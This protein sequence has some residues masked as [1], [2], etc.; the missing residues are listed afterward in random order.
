MFPQ[1]RKYTLNLWVTASLE[2]MK[3]LEK[4]A[5]VQLVSIVN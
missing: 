1:S 5:S 2:G 4:T 3:D